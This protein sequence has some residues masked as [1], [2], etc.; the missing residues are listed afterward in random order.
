MGK[1]ADSREAG[2]ALYVA[3]GLFVHRL[4]QVPVQEELTL[5]ERSALTRL[6]R[7][8]SATPGALARLSQISPQ[9]M[10]ATLAALEKRG[11]V[12]RHPDPEDGRRVVMSVT[13]AGR[14]MLDDKRTARAE[15]LGRVLR[16]NFTPS[17]I[18]TL[19]EAVPLIQRLGELV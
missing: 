13:A 19:M 9:G 14:R 2:A 11:L 5:S 15:Q 18:E 6:E 8:G 7:S 3:I 1:A 4:R 12:Q 10:G 17:E 16:E